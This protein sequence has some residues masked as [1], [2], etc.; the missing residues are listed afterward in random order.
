[1]ARLNGRADSFGNVAIRLGYATEK[2]VLEALEEQEKRLPL[3]EIMVSKGF[4]TR[5][6][7]EHILHVQEVEN[8]KTLVEKTQIQLSFQKRKAREVVISLKST[9]EAMKNFSANGELTSDVGS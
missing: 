5:E 6:Q 2:D 7:L 8:A 3:G 9:T 4:L 1:M